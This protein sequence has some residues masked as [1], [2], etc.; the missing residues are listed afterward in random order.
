MP[1]ACARGLHSRK[2]CPTCVEAGPLRGASL[3]V[4]VGCGWLRAGWCRDES[5]LHR[6]TAFLA[7][8]H[9]LVTQVLAGIDHT[10]A[11]LH[12]LYLAL[13]HASTLLMPLPQAPNSPPSSGAGSGSGS[14]NACGATAATVVV[15]DTPAVTSARAAV[16]RY[17]ASVSACQR[18][19]KA[20]ILD[21]RIEAA[22]NSRWNAAVSACSVK[23]AVTKVWCPC[24][25][26][27][28]WS[29]PGR[30]QR[31]PRL[32]FRRRVGVTD[33]SAVA[34]VPRRVPVA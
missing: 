10:P 19:A 22:R 17:N 24:S 3:W 34:G 25:A 9:V 8:H 33:A 13:A 2:E 23:A 12:S 14:N 15:V 7:R 30:R 20:T 4:R 11:E 6:V 18:A 28:C 29:C 21:A 31:G 16:A 26:W 32:V 1:E 5:A 27:R